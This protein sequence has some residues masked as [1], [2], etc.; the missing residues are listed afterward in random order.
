ML[1]INKTLSSKITLVLCYIMLAAM[2]ALTISL[3]WVWKFIVSLFDS[4]ADYY[5]S[6]LFFLYPACFLGITTCIL[7]EAG[8]YLSNSLFK[9]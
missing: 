1:K 5:L 2:T 9:L 7:I 8:C 6:S 3:P 4:K